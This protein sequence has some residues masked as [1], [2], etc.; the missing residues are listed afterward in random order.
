MP[1]DFYVIVA[2]NTE[3]EP[4]ET[5]VPDLA[6]FASFHAEFVAGARAALGRSADG[7]VAEMIVTVQSGAT[8]G[9]VRAR[10]TRVHE[11]AAIV[12]LERHALDAAGAGGAGAAAAP[13]PS[14]PP[15]WVCTAVLFAGFADADDAAIDLARAMWLFEYQPEVLDAIRE[16]RR[17]AVVLTFP[18]REH[19]EDPVPQVLMRAVAEAFLGALGVEAEAP[20]GPWPEPTT[21]ME[22]P[23]G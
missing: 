18:R 1:Y 13:P 19:F 15:V 21:V 22:N 6:P 17:P 3:D 12:D 14:A 4:R 7:G 9:H 20:A 16:R 2:Q 5:R 10:L 11:T 8:P 23:K